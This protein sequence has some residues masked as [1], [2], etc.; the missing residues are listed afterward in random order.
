MDLAQKNKLKYF[1][2]KYIPFSDLKKAGFFAKDVRK[3]DYEKIAARVCHT[4]G[5]KSIYEYKFVCRGKAC[6]G[7]SCDGRHELCKN[8][9]QPGIKFKSFKADIPEI[10][11]AK[12]WLN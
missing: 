2:E 6:D 7:E 4:F 3:T 1:I 12:S 8:Y 5:Y 9:K 11:T 10:L